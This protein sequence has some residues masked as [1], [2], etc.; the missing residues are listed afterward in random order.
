MS[1][2]EAVK[3]LP[4]FSHVSK[5]MLAYIGSDKAI[6]DF[7]MGVRI[8]GVFTNVL[9]KSAYFSGLF[10]LRNKF[11]V[12]SDWFKKTIFGRDIGRD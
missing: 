10:S 12:A 11:S 9:W 5:G 4:P 6:A 2:A 1:T 7:P 3:A 8:G